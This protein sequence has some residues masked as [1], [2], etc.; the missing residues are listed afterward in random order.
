MLGAEVCSRWGPRCFDSLAVAIARRYSIVHTSAV[1]THLGSSHHSPG[2]ADETGGPVVQEK[3]EDANKADRGV[4]K[5]QFS[6]AEIR[7][8]RTQVEER[9]SQ[10]A[11]QEQA[12][13]RGE[14]AHGVTPMRGARAQQLAAWKEVKRSIN[15]QETERKRAAG[16]ISLLGKSDVG[17]AGGPSGGELSAAWATDVDGWRKV[18]VVMDS[19]AAECVAPRSMAPQFAI[20]DSPASRAGVYYTSANGGRLDNL[21]QQELPIAFESGVRAMTTW[22]IADV[23][24]PLMSVGKITELGNRVLFGSAGGVI[25][26]LASGQVTPFHM[27]DGVYVFTMWIPPLSQTPFVG[28]R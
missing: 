20:V 17:Q 7:A 3:D 26:N 21:G 16:E 8:M 15:E 18:K 19:G 5:P 28:Q 1:K 25:L 10:L 12:A 14:E 27:E 2:A 11:L 9:A 6:E 13:A 22:Q 4:S 23:S 24:R